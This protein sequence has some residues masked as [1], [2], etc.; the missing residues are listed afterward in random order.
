MKSWRF[1]KFGAFHSLRLED[2]PVPT[3]A[4]DEC[5]V[6]L[7]YA[8]LNPAD[9]LLIMG[10]YPTTAR[11]PFSVG[12]DGSGTVVAEAENGRFHRGDRVVCLRSIIGIERDGTLADYV[13]VP[14]THLAPL[15]EG[16]SAR[17]GAA[18]PHALLT[19]WQ[20]LVEV[21]DLQAGETVVITGASGGIGTAALILA[22]AMGARVIALS[23]SDAKRHKLI[24]LG[25]HA[26]FG[27]HAPD[28]PQ[29]VKSFGG[30]DVVV[31][32][33]CGDCL[34]ALL[35]ACNPYG[36]VCIVGAL[37]GTSST[38][39]P[40]HLIFNRL[41]LHGIQVAMY[42]DTGVQMAWEEIVRLI[43]PL[44]AKVPIEAV[45]PFSGVKE[46]FE[47]LRQGPFGKVLIAVGDRGVPD[48]RRDAIDT[49]TQPNS[50]DHD[51][52]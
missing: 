18:G 20:A 38:I 30:A 23:R 17:D 33:V 28:T 49:T 37:G 10:R 39:D 1:H 40:T 43:G 24:A 50:N 14:E 22:R 44:H 12:R 11:P 19:S 36:R 41:Q 48:D 4:R 9:R 45:F 7:A 5:L 29:K 47:R 21:A 32:T 16:W 8:A 34:P 52:A 51:R 42:S 27:T 46:A 15:P 13:C 26:A 6:K 25:A 2:V 35:P 31:E 3:P